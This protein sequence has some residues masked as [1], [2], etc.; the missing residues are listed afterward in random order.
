MIM[1]GF[2]NYLEVFQIKIAENLF[3][4]SIIG[5]GIKLLQAQAAFY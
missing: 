1:R 4:S 5:Y 2:C 3:V